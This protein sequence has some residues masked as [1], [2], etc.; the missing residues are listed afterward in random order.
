MDSLFFI[1]SS[2]SSKLRLVILRYYYRFPMGPASVSA[3]MVKAYRKGC[4]PSSIMYE[5]DF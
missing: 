4:L 1:L 3:G 5:M 2:G